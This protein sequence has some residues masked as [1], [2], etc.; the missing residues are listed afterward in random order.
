MLVKIVIKKKA[1]PVKKNGNIHIFLSTIS[2]SRVR[3][4]TVG[5]YKLTKNNYYLQRHQIIDLYR[6]TD[7]YAKELMLTVIFNI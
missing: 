5:A 4:V 6:E 7:S 3:G 2:F 1:G